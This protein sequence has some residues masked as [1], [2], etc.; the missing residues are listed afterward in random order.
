MKKR[1]IPH[2]YIKKA[3]TKEDNIKD[4]D[5]Q[6]EDPTKNIDKLPKEM[7]QILGDVISFME[8][9]NKIEGEKNENK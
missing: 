1:L 5:F 6:L 9:I 8:N 4:E 2:K 7:F 3:Y